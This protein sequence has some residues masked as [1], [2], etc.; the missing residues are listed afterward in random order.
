MDWAMVGHF[1]NWKTRGG[2]MSVIE[3]ET[4]TVETLP[5]LVKTQCEL[6]IVIAKSYLSVGEIE[7][8]GKLDKCAMVGVYF[9]ELAVWAMVDAKLPMEELRKVLGEIPTKSVEVI[10]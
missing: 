10:R 6:R 2:V 1:C 4:E 8:I 3:T 7:D 5:Q 9:G